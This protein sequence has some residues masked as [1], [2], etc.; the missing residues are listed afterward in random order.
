[1]VVGAVLA[2]VIAIKSRKTYGAVEEIFSELEKVTWPTRK[3]TS[4]ATM[5]VL[6][7]VA[8]ASVILSVF[9]AVWSFLT[10]RILS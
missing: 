9:D 6:V 5:V 3:E 8:I 2:G 7:T 1:M 4:A 10:G